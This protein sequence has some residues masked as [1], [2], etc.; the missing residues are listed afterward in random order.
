MSEPTTKKQ[1]T[2]NW[3]DCATTDLDAADRCPTTHT[4]LRPNVVWFG[5]IPHHLEEVSE[6]LETC[7]VFCAIGTSGLVYPAAG[8]VQ[9][10]SQNFAHTVEINLERTGGPFAEARLGRASKVVPQWADELIAQ[11][12]ST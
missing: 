11:A 7:T 8:L 6:F 9:V 10:A 5:E 2:P 4:R 1:G 3:A 12:G